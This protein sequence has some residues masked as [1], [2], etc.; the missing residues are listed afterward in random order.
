MHVIKLT[1]ITLL[2]FG[3]FAP[4]SQ[5]ESVPGAAEAAQG[6][7]TLN[8]DVVVEGEIVRLGDIFTGLGDKAEIA[9]ARAPALGKKVPVG[10][11]WLTAVAQKYAL[12]WRASSRLDRAVIQ[13]A[14][15]IIAPQEIKAR[16]RDALFEEGVQQNAMLEFDTPSAQLIL[17]QEQGDGITIT[18]LSFDAASGRFTAQVA[19]PAEGVPV[20]KTTLRGR[21]IRV[22]EVPV[23]NR[24]IE[25]GEIVRAQDLNWIDHRADRLMRNAIRDSESIVGK[26]ARRPIG[27]GVVIKASELRTPQ[28]VAKNSLVTIRLETER[29]VLTAQ[30]RAL[31]AGTMGEAIQV[32]NTKSNSIIS[33]EVVSR[34]T[35]RAKL[36]NNVVIN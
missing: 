22:V 36:S 3:L 14:V 32:M 15:N 19:A 25:A 12:P 23:L 1:V 29:M 26:S 7:V 16:V 6:I 18:S 28:I 13:R 10:V 27:A 21:A 24:R 11:R 9:I 33:A 20:A 35:V 17:P 34:G 4:A 5:A 31:Q 8:R 30:G 2:A